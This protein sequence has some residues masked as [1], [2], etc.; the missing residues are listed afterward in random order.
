MAEDDRHEVTARSFLS[1]AAEVAQLL[2][3]GT[4]TD[5]PED[6]R[7]RHLA[8]AVRKPLLERAGLPEELFAPLMAAAVYDP[9]PS[10]CRWF[11]EPAVYAF[12]RRKVMT[13]LLA[14]SGRA[15]KRSE[16]APSGRG[17][18]PTCRYVQI[19]PQ[20]M[21]PPGVAIQPWMK[22]ATLR[23]S[24][25]RFP[26]HSCVNRPSHGTATKPDAAQEACGTGFKGGNSVLC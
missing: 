23:T 2:D 22:P 10:F 19:D 21:H 5:V 4:G 16:Q 11:V 1:C 7:A 9:D 8:H 12:G 3:L 18:A 24:G 20:P 13:A 25:V 17:T 6:R 26:A 15:R 14:Y